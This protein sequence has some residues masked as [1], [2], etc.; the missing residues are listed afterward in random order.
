M[1]LTLVAGGEGLRAVTGDAGR[2]M[3]MLKNVVFKQMN[4]SC[5]L[6][7]ILIE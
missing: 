5:G 6:L 7:K 3:F 2:S 1:K 4:T